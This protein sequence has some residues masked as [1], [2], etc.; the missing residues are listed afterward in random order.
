[1]LIQGNESSKAK[2]GHNASSVDIQKMKTI[3]S[4]IA[5]NNK[6]VDCDASSKN[7]YIFSTYFKRLGYTISLAL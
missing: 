7:K 6:C 5:G 4:D 3:K 1:M 2:G